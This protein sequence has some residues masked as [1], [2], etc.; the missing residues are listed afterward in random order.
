MPS[1]KLQIVE[2]GRA[3]GYLRKGRQF[4]EAARQQ[5]DLNHFEAA[6]LCAVHAGISSCDAVCVALGGRRSAD[7]NHALAADLLESVGQSSEA[8]RQKAN[9]LRQLLALKNLIEYEDKP[10]RRAE[11][12]S[13]VA[14]SERLVTWAVD[15][16]TRARL[17]VR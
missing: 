15:V 5:L 10:A 2:K 6:L 14:R 11:T 1:V 16:V 7:P 4:A 13:G 12:E 17:P 8:F 3:P 9:Q